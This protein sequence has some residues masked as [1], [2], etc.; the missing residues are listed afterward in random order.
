MRYLLFVYI[1]GVAMSLIMAN[2]TSVFEVS[3]AVR[4]QDTSLSTNGP[5]CIRDHPDIAGSITT[6]CDRGRSI[7]NLT[8]NA[9]D[10]GVIFMNIVPTF[11]CPL[12]LTMSIV[13]CQRKMYYACANMPEPQ[14]QIYWGPD[15]RVM[16]VLGGPH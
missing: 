14:H 4:D 9:D 1:T 5:I 7:E 2:P 3:I 12:P 15:E 11:W 8:N 6:Y 16:F 10:T 13:E